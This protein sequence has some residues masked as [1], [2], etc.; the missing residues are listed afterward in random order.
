MKPLV[1]NVKTFKLPPF[2]Y[3][4]TVVHTSD[5]SRSAANRAS[6]FGNQVHSLG[7]NCEA[8]TWTRKGCNAVYVMLPHQPGVNALTH[9]VFHAVTFVL[10]DSGIEFE[11]EVWAYFLGDLTEKVAKFCY[12]KP[13]VL[14]LAPPTTTAV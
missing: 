14:K 3:A 6:I 11:E 13:A 9:E 10:R 7:D 4:V 2:S 8:F 12:A 1:E 5:V